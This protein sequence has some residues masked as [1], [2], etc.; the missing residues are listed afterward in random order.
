M[1]VERSQCIE[2]AWTQAF[3]KDKAK[4]KSFLLQAKSCHCC[5]DASKAKTLKWKIDSRVCVCTA[6]LFWIPV[7]KYL[8]C[9]VNSKQATLPA[10]GVKIATWRCD[11]DEHF[12][13][14][15]V[16]IVLLSLYY[17]TAERL[18]EERLRCLRFYFKNHFIVEFDLEKNS[19]W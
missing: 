9:D 3:T 7:V 5:R 8:S 12:I 1:S 13:S 17:I 14:F 4:L 15:S 10:A 6:V 18:Q 2:I 19:E 16:A 11:L